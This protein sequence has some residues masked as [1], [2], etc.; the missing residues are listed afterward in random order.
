[1]V[2]NNYYPETSE[3][4]AEWWENVARNGAAP[5]AAVGFTEE[6]IKSV[7]N[8]AAWAQYVYG[9]VRRYADLWEAEVAAYAARIAAG[10]DADG[11][12]PEPPVPAQWP[13]P[14]RVSI[15]CNFERRRV[16]WVQEA[17]SAPS[18]TPEIGE[19]LGIVPLA[20]FNSWTFRAVLDGLVC[21]GPKTVMGR[22]R[23]ASG[24]IEGIVLRGRRH[25][26]AGWTE[27]GRF[28]ATPFT[29]AVPLSGGTPQEEWEFQAR[30]IKRDL[31]VGVPSD[32]VP[33]T[34]EA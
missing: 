7:M 21:T 5:F 26:S 23:K 32:I 27:L 12:A 33:A 10:V 8:D 4:R 17:K 25:G 13:E 15:E 1:M 9:A 24:N 22:F 16:E 11:L 34:V 14:P 31:E 29:A 2:T 3:G 19:I 18:Y 30:A 28:N 20:D 6:Q